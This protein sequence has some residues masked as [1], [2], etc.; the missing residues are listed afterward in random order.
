MLG[1]GADIFA[2]AFTGMVRVFE[3]MKASN[4]GKFQVPQCAFCWT[5]L[6]KR[7]IAKGGMHC[8]NCDF[9]QSLFLSQ[10]GD[11]KGKSAA[12]D[13]ALDTCFWC[14]EGDYGTV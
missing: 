11:M 12:V 10:R 4:E 1:I 8:L 5:D 14:G 13:L 9:Y 2:I 6:D 3:F 7:D